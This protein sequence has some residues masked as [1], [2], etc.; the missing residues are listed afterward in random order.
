MGWRVRL[1]MME[2]FQV[3]YGSEGFSLI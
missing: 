1:R 3:G 2:A